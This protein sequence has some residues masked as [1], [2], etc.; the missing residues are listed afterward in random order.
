MASSLGGFYASLRMEVDQPTFDKLKK[1]L[2]GVKETIKKTGVEFGK[3]VGDVI[4]GF[5]LIGGAAMGAAYAVSNIQGKM[6]LTAKNAG[7]GYTELNKWSTAMKLVGLDSAGLTSK[8]SAVNEALADYKVGEN[9]EAYQSLAES[10]AKLTGSGTTGININDFAKMSATERIMAVTGKAEQARGTD[11]ERAMLDLAD[12]ILGVG[13]LLQS[14][15]M[16]G[17][18][19]KTTADLL[20]ASSG[21]QWQNNADAVNGVKNSQSFN[22][23]Q[24]TLDQ[25]WMMAGNSLATTFRPIIDDLTKFLN[26]N[27]D[28]IRKFFDDLSKVIKSLITTLG[29]AVGA[30]AD[31][32]GNV[33][34]AVANNPD[35]L[36]KRLEFEKSPAGQKLKAGVSE[37]FKNSPWFSLKMNE[38]MALKNAEAYAMQGKSY[39]AGVTQKDIQ[40]ANIPNVVNVGGVNVTLTQE[41]LAL[42]VAFKKSGQLPAMDSETA[43][44]QMAVIALQMS[45]T[46]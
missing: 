10:L 37:T 43:A 39:A 33:V 17:S 6:A 38:E 14:E 30:I 36:K 3:F 34:D 31:T 18:R 35:R 20:N 5:S 45:S 8:M 29:P 21:L 15:T 2:D 13:D 27:K 9:V 11:K 24:A 19:Y 41:A 16:A 25:M 23:F 4:K 44:A 32:V 22:A 40:S 1:E 28:E 26:E 42:A 7:M 12:K 46:K